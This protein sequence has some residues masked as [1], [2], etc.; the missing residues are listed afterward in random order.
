MHSVMVCSKATLGF[1]AYLQD[2][3]TMLI[4]FAKGWFDESFTKQLLCV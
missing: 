3:V 4:R 1:V 2:V